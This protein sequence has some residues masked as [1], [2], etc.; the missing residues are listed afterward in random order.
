MSTPASLRKA[1][2]LFSGGQDSTACLAWALAQHGRALALLGRP[3]EA[4]ASLQRAAGQFAARDNRV[5]GAAVAL[6]QSGL[7]RIHTR[8][9]TLPSGLE[10]RMYELD[11]R[12]MEAWAR[13]RHL[14]GWA[15]R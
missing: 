1:L 4:R 12:R 11:L 6:V 5:G 3:G 9:T 13:E 2:V 7:A 15:G 14:G 8:G 10:A